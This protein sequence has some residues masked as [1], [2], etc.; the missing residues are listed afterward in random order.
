MGI[1]SSKLCL[2]LPLFLYCISQMC[3][4]SALAPALARYLSHRENL[5]C[6]R[7]SCMHRLQQVPLHSI[8]IYIPLP[9]N[10]IW[11]IISIALGIGMVVVEMYTY[12]P[13][14]PIGTVYLITL[15]YPHQLNNYSILPYSGLGTL[16]LLITASF[17]CFMQ[18]S[19]AA[20]QGLCSALHCLLLS[21]GACGW[22]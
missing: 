10:L 14:W 8:F 9:P 17:G 3:I 13:I 6:R 21:V 20:Q 19:L 4:Q 2:Y 16:S 11:L 22:Y 15:C 1:Y 18:K 12:M 7:G 5:R